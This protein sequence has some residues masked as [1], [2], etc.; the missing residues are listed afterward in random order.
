MER[1]FQAEG[2]AVAKILRHECNL[3]GLSRK[4]EESSDSSRV[5]KWEYKAPLITASPV[6]NWGAK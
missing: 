3:H 1:T 2:L 6:F 4:R 5:S